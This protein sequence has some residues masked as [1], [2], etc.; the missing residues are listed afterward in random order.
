VPQPTTLPRNSRDTAFKRGHSITQKYVTV[1]IFVPV[2]T[3]LNSFTER[4]VAAMCIPLAFLGSPVQASAA[5]KF[6]VVFAQSFQPDAE[7]D[8]K[9]LQYFFP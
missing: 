4:D 2:S 3:V 8:R 7:I 5:L 6:C 1:V 9:I